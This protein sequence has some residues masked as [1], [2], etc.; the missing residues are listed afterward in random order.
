MK[1]FINTIISS[2]LAIVFTATTAFA[3]TTPSPIRGENAKFNSISV[4]GN[5]EVTVKQGSRSS[6]AYSDDNTGSVKVTECGGKLCISTKGNEQAKVTVYV[7]DLF[8]I[9]AADHAIVKTEGK[10]ETKFLQLFLSDYAQ[11][12]INSNTDGLYTVLKDHANLSLSGATK[13]HALVMGNTPSLSMNQFAALK[14][15]TQSLA[16]YSA[17]YALRK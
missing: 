17:T 15:S 6:I 12:N 9:Q 14:T 4:Q 13:D 1:T 16:E 11:A 5:V 8:R 10:I 7:K 3:G 2:S